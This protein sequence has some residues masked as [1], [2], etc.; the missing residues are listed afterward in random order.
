M[1]APAAGGP[2]LE[3]VGIQKGFF[4]VPVLKGVSLSLGGG[5]VLGLVGENGAGKSTL[6]NVLGGVLGPEGGSMRL[7]GEPYAP[8]S[9][10]AATARGVAFVH[11]ELNLFPN[12][13]VAENVFLHALPRRGPL[14]D[15]ARLESRTRHLLGEVGLDVPPAT[16]VEEPRAGRAAAGRDREGA[17][18][19][20]ARRDLSTSPRRPS[21][22]RRRSA[23]SPSWAACGR[24]A[25]ASSTSRT[26]SATCCASPTTSS[27]CATGRWWARGRGPSS[28]R[29]AW[30]R[31]WW[32]GRS[33]PSS[34]PA[35][36]RPPARWP[37]RR[38]APRRAAA[39]GTCGFTLHRGEVVGLAGL[40]GAGRTEALRALFGLDTLE[41]GEVRVA[42]RTL[43]PSPRSRDCPRP[44][45]RDR[46]P[47]RRTASCWTR[48]SPTTSRSW[49]LPSLASRGLVPPAR[50]RDGGG[51][52]G[53]GRPS[54]VGH[55]PFRAGAQPLRRQPAEG[56]PRQVADGEARRLPAGR[57]HPRR[58]TSGRSSRSTG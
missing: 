55:R 50:V 28:T 45:V 27:S 19:R 31:S 43:A 7:A 38:G 30:S 12:L 41:G 8:A 2:L 6:L 48:R 9:P 33:R 29:L 17:G 36:P 16:L 13:S 21:A 52:P 37:S 3:L 1:S 25:S 39:S 10:S 5:R 47:P 49:P 15:R 54:R 42:G 22:P 26:R 35:A 46:G 53:G 18:G 32:A 58:S 11:Q 24:R 51:R 20:G 56:R 23:S 57:A 40:M 14:V 34:P 4:G 44:G